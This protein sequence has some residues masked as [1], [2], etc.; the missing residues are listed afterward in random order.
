MKMNPAVATKR[1][2][3]LAPVMK[4][5][6]NKSGRVLIERVGGNGWQGATFLV[7]PC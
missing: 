6:D 1:V 7:L 4:P 3:T 2:K 5:V